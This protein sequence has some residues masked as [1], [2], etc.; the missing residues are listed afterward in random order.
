[1][2]QVAIL[3]PVFVQVFLTLGVLAALAVARARAIRT[4]DRQRGNP[5]LAM[6]RAAWP[7][8]ATKRAAN[9]RNQF[10]LPVLFYAVAAFA[11]LTRGAD[12]SMIILAWLFVLTRAIHAAIHV[13]PNQV[14]WRTPAYALGFLI[15]I[16]MWIRLLLH[17]AAS[18]PA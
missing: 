11:L 9:F 10:E 6:G 12:L 1:L 16:I 2:N 14:R 5:E 13:G 15:L 17:V 3:Y 4:M 8:D 7:D 18:G